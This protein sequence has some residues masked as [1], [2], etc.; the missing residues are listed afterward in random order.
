M[1]I[2]SVRIRNFRSFKEET[3]KFDGY[4]CLVGANG[5]GKS[6]VLHALNVFFRESQIPGLDPNLL[7]EEDFHR[8]NTN[9]PVELTVTFEDLNEEAQKD[10]AHY[11]RQHELVVSA[12]AHFNPAT[13]TAEVKQFGR[14]LVMKAFA[15]FFKAEKE[16]QR[17]AELKN[18]YA[19]LRKAYPELPSP[20]AKPAMLH[21]LRSFEE[22]HSDQCE[23]I[24]SNDQFYGFPRG[25]NLLEKHIQWVY[26]PAVKDAST[27]DVEARNTVLGKIL[28]RTVRAKINFDEAIGGIRTKAQ[29]EY[30][31]LLAKSQ[32]ALKE[33]SG[34]LQA[35]LREWAHPDARVRLKWRQNLE[36]SV[37]IDEPFAQASAGEGGFEGE[38]TRFGHGLQRSYLL[39]LLQELSGS[40]AA[41]GPRMILACEEPELYQHPPQ[42]RHLHNVLLKLSSGNSQVILCTHSPYFV[43]GEDFESVRLLRKDSVHSRVYRATYTEVSQTISR[44]TGKAPAKPAGELAKIHQ[45]LQPELSEMFFAQRLVLVEGLEDVAY[46]VSYLHLLQ[47]WDEYRRLGYHMIPTDG[48]SEMLQPLAIAKC[49]LIPAFVVFD[50][51]EDKPDTNG[52]REKHRQD[53]VAI[54][55]LCGVTSPQPFPDSHFVGERVVMWASD[56]G[57]AVEAEIGEQEWAG[58]RAEVDTQFGHTGGL[59]KNALHIANS[60]RIAWDR[61]K[62][63]ASLEELCRKIMEF[64]KANGK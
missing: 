15:P 35:R 61:G 57:K 6:N 12:V 47:L 29:E 40:D 64:G 5:S 16:G 17:V 19:D 22:G 10:V 33:V 32:D 45:A 41:A 18:V 37:R 53:N 55:T 3:V 23:E 2:K 54:L 52:S 46:I 60:L 50:S 39:A 34:T 30:D 24:P 13:R 26:V 14:R 49:L 20:G 42:A 11:F 43:S 21:A 7:Q 56:I 63:S 28:A 8:K 27:E 25:A 1:R 51:D 44:A 9:E 59:R 58:F 48:K 31:A 4:T 38:L 36:K 62:K